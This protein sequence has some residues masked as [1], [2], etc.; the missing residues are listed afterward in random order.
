MKDEVKAKLTIREKSLYSNIAAMT[1]L[2]DHKA[3]IH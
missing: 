3:R 1:R 2:N